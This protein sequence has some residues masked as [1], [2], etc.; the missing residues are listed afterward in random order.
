MGFLGSNYPKLFFFSPQLLCLPV[1]TP[2]N[3]MFGILFDFSLCNTVRSQLSAV[4]QL[5]NFSF[6]SLVRNSIKF[7]SF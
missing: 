2:P 4:I 6:S 3:F 1:E 7:L 5:G